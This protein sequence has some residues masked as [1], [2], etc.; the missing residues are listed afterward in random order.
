MNAK[1]PIVSGDASRELTSIQIIS[2]ALHNAALKA[3]QMKLSPEL[4]NTV[5]PLLLAT[6]HAMSLSF[7]KGLDTPIEVLALST[8]NTF[9]LY[10][11]LVHI[12]RSQENRRNWRGEA[13]ID[14]L[15]ILDGIKA[16]DGPEKAKKEIYEEIKRV[17]NHAVKQGVEVGTRIPPF[18]K[19]AAESGL[20]PEYEAFFKLYSK[21]VHPS[22]FTVNWPQAASTPVYRSIFTF[23]IQTYGLLVLKMLNS[24]FSIQTDKLLEQSRKPFERIFQRHNEKGGSEVI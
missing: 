22:S 3:S 18:K 15:Q 2:L 13:F 11:R 5:P 4:A 1:H 6:S 14:Q 10:T 20:M 17:K 19:L 24:E 16:I 21:F 23:N 7:L 8:R 9:E 12:L